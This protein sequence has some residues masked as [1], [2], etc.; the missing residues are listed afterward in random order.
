MTPPPHT[1]M[2]GRTCQHISSFLGC[3][4]P[5]VALLI[6]YVHSFNRSRNHLKGACQVTISFVKERDFT[7][8]F[9]FLAHST[10]NKCCLNKTKDLV[11][12]CILQLFLELCSILLLAITGSAIYS[13]ISI[14][15]SS[16]KL[17]LHY[18]LGHLSTILTLC[19]EHW[20]Q[21]PEE[22]LSCSGLPPGLYAGP[23]L[24]QVRTTQPGCFWVKGQHLCKVLGL[25]ELSFELRH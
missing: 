6:R 20:F 18:Y 14:L 13:P 22:P 7:C 24:A 3:A 25:R 11:L 23:I 9:V 19:W 12:N 16:L 17:S 4:Q 10:F 15:V 2:L 8:I 1:S 5:K 21:I